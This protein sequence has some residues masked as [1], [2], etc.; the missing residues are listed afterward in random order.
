MSCLVEDL[1]NIKQLMTDLPTVLPHN[2]VRHCEVGCWTM[3]EVAD[4]KAVW[5]TTVLMNHQEVSHSI[6]SKKMHWKCALV[7]IQAVHFTYKLPSAV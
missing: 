6:C 5:H 1:F 4:N 2:N 3:R 7:T